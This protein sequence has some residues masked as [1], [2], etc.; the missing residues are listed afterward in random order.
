MRV[1]LLN[2]L[3]L[4]L[5]LF[6]LTVVAAIEQYPFA[7]NKQQADFTQ[8]THKLRCLVCQ[9]QDLADSNAPLAQ[10]LRAEIYQKIKSGESKQAITDYMTARY[11]DFILYKPP[12]NLTTYVLWF[13][14]FIIMLSAFSILVVIIKRRYQ[15]MGPEA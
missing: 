13:A 1:Y 5:W 2:L 4:L 12:V 3:G 14:P 9:N 10:D 15:Q 8:L 11:G 7:N 6:S